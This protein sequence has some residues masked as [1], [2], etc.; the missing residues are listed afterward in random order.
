MSAEDIKIT[1]K[2]EIKQMKNELNKREGL[3]LMKIKEASAQ[4]EMNR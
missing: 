1:S 4:L 2:R 3:N